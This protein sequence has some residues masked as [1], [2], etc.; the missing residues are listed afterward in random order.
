[1]KKIIITLSFLLSS[2]ITLLGQNV[3]VTVHF[4]TGKSEL[5]KV[6]KQRI[7][8]VFA[9]LKNKELEQCRV[10]GHTDRIGTEKYNQTLS[11]KRAEAVGNYLISKGLDPDLLKLDAKNYSSPIALGTT[12]K[13]RQ[14]NRRAKLIIS[15]MIERNEGKDTAEDLIEEEVVKEEKIESIDT[16]YLSAETNRFK[17]PNDAYVI[18][19]TQA[20]LVFTIEPNTFDVAEGDSLELIVNNEYFDASQIVEDQL[21]TRSGNSS[22]GSRGMFG[23]EVK[24]DGKQA[25]IKEGVNFK[26]EV[27]MSWC[28]DSF[29]IY[30]AKGLDEYSNWVLTN[31]SVFSEDGSC[32]L[33]LAEAG[34]MINCD[35]LVTSELIVKFKTRKKKDFLPYCFVNKQVMLTKGVNLKKPF[36]NEI[37]RKMLFAFI[38]PLEENDT[39]TFIGY[40][41]DLELVQ[42][43]IVFNNQSVKKKKYRRKKY[44]MIRKSLFQKELLYS[45]KIPSFFAKY[46]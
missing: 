29:N 19:T 25:M 14:A 13:D 4:Q 44:A 22:L 27:P 5:S 40:N 39:L 23:Y 3:S 34:N 26:V 12:K 43:Y 18:I 15:W 17:F 6:A 2:S 7:D 37:A 42:A 20:G 31:K 36:Q 33:L 45:N 38:E 16:L 9:P 46:P 8:S 1:M 28:N 21:S 11:M 41:K 32:Y 35:K 30:S 10:V 24:V